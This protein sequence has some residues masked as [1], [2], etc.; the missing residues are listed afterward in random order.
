MRWKCRRYVRKE[1]LDFDSNLRDPIYSLS[2]GDFPGK[3]IDGSSKS[4][5]E[6]MK[7][8]KKKGYSE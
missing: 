8:I 3:D 7:R 5:V 6:F 4:M 2:F 1:R